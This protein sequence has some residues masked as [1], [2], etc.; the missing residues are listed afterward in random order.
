MLPKRPPGDQRVGFIYA[1]PWRIQ[2]ISVGGEQTIIQIPELGLNFDIGLCPR[3]GI[4]APY[5][6]L[7]HGHMDHVA[8]LPYWFSQ[9][10]FMKLGGGTCFCHPEL[11][12]PLRKM[13]AGW[14]DVENQQTPHTI[15]SIAPGETLLLKPSLGLKALSASHTVPALSYVAFERRSKLRPEFHGLPQTKLRELKSNDQVITVTVDV[16]LVAYT[17]DTEMNASLVSTDFCES[18]VVVTECT[19]FE[20]DHV[21]RAK[22]GRHLHVDHLRELMTV[23]KAETVVLGHLSR[24]STLETVR[25]KLIEKLGD[26]AE[27]VCILM[28]HHSNRMRYESQV[29]AVDEPEKNLQ[30]V[31]ELVDGHNKES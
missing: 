26:D 10:S 15:T 3:I 6:A 8:A 9:R 20:D 16:P 19:F 17:G 1:P 11:A 27:R 29:V 4:A 5:T 18:K 12:G 24:R 7:S 25:K 23:W 2:G 21:D 22:H 31:K 13:M 28:D 14:I 30:S